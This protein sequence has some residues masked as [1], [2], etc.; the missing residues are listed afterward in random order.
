MTDAAGRWK[1][2]TVAVKVIEHR[3]AGN[4]SGQGK[5]AGQEEILATSASHPN[6]VSLV[7]R[8]RQASVV[9]PP[10]RLDMAIWPWLVAT[11]TCVSPPWY[12]VLQAVLTAQLCTASVLSPLPA[13]QCVP[14]LHDE[15]VTAQQHDT[16]LVAGKLKCGQQ[17]ICPAGGGAAAQFQQQL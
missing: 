7:A 14:R 2:S 16:L 9:T 13:G 3:A 1:A 12:V 8:C 11:A 4:S 10:R 15:C 5:S 17:A 6:V